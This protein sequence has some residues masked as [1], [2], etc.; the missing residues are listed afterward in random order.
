MIASPSPL[1]YRGRTR[2]FVL[3]GEVGYR[4]FQSNEIEPIEVVCWA[5]AGW[6]REAYIAAY[7]RDDLEEDGPVFVG[8]C[9]VFPIDEREAL[10]I[11]EWSTLDVIE[12]FL[13]AQRTGEVRE[14]TYLD[15]RT[16]TG[17]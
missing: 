14:W 12:R 15:G 17:Q 16:A 11:D 13:V 1:G 5:I 8:N 6:R 7:E 9:G 4:R 10:D 3:E 2:L